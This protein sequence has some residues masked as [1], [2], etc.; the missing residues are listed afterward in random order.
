[1]KAIFFVLATLFLA[2]AQA[3]IGFGAL[4]GVHSGQADTD[5][6][7]AKMNSKTGFHFGVL[8]LVPIVSNFEMRSGF[9]YNQRYAEIQ[10]TAAGNVSLDFSYFDV[11]LT[12]MFRLSEAAGIF[13]GPV[14]A[15]NQSKEVTCTNRANCAALDVKSVVLPL[16]LGVN[17]KFMSQAGGELYAEYVAGDLSTNVSDMK[18]VGANFIFYFE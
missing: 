17:F 11:P 1:M 15:F 14:V 10:N 12:P 6:A 4:A 8:A 7:G 16:Q 9:I 2:Q 13:A 3:Q 18:T 5:I